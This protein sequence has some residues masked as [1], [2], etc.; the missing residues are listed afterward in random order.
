MLLFETERECVKCLIKTK[1]KL[2]NNDTA[3]KLIDTYLDLID[4][5]V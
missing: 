3:L 2:D 4:Y 1:E 5:D